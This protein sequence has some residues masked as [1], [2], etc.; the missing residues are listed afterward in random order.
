[1]LSQHGVT[2]VLCLTVISTQQHYCVCFYKAVSKSDKL[3]IEK[4]LL[5][6]IYLSVCVIGV[7]LQNDT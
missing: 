7:Q 5:C 6:N 4:N 1:M 3:L 2:C